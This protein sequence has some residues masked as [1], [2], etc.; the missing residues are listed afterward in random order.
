M[1][2]MKLTSALIFFLLITPQLFYGTGYSSSPPM[3]TIKRDHF[4]Q[5]IL[6]TRDLGN[7]VH[8][9]EK[10]F[11]FTALVQD[12]YETGKARTIGEE[13]RHLP[14]LS[15]WKIKLDLPKLALN[16]L[17][18]LAVALFISGTLHLILRSLHRKRKPI[19]YPV[20]PD[21]NQHNFKS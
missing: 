1:I 20:L 11:P 17:F 12:T 13:A 16:L 3:E 15:G 18:A 6:S 14:R 4:F 5:V 21:S 8:H 10:G 9:N 7:S 19:P 2:K